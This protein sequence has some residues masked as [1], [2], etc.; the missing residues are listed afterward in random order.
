MVSGNDE[1]NE[2][3]TERHR[4]EGGAK[5]GTR[6]AHSQ[7]NPHTERTKTTR[8]AAS[9][10]PHRREERRDT[11]AKHEGKGNEKVRNE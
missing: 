3:G 2:R 10:P 11:T 1:I 8:W 9:P 5:K 6:D 7:P 4:A